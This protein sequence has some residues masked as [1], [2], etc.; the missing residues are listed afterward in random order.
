MMAMCLLTSSLLISVPVGAASESKG[1]GW[2]QMNKGINDG[3]KEDLIIPKGYEIIAQGAFS[4]NKEIKTIRMADSVKKIEGKAF[5]QTYIKEIHIGK[6]VTYMA[7]NV[8]Q[9]ADGL[10][11]LTVAPGNPVYEIRNDALYN[12]VTKSLMWYPPI[13]EPFDYVVPE[14]TKRIE[15]YAFGELFRPAKGLKKITLPDTVEFIGDN[16]FY[17]CDNLEEFNVPA[18]LK[19]A[20][21]GSLDAGKNMKKLEIPKGFVKLNSSNGPKGYEE[22]NV[23]PENKYYKSI[24][25]VLFN[26]DGTVLIKYPE[27]KKGERYTIPQGVIKIERS[28]FQ[29]NFNLKEVVFPK[30]LKVIQDYSFDGVPLNRLDLP[31]SVEY[32]GDCSFSNVKVQK[33]ILPANLQVTGASLFEKRDVGQW[34]KGN[35]VEIVA[36]SPNTRFSGSMSYPYIFTKNEKDY[37]KVSG[38]SGGILEESTKQYGVN[39]KSTGPGKNIINSGKNYLDYNNPLGKITKEKSEPSNVSKEII[40]NPKDGNLVIPEGTVYIDET[41]FGGW[42][43]EDFSKIKSIKLPESLEH[44]GVKGLYSF[45]DLK[46]T[47]VIPK[48]VQYIGSYALPYQKS[49]KSIKFLNPEITIGPENFI[50]YSHNS[51]SLRESQGMKKDPDFKIIGHKNS[52]IHHLANAHGIKFEAIK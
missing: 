38:P 26:K 37:I 4:L 2:S 43:Y 33:V 15:T 49:P 52:S 35:V 8:F 40:K 7:E 23:H 47:L 14:G 21:Y 45:N 44:I 41:T 39:F 27:Y 46:D 28:A 20:G 25:G 51:I 31:D 13:K 22:I 50:Y 12:K 19:Y 5:D 36:K 32:I 48:N 16:I 10:E 1:Y 34:Y 29:N 3:T 18:N 9:Q 11:K 17:N 6:G 24:D 30:G 42:D